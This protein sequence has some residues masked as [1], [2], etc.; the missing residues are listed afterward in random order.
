VPKAGFW[1][2]GGYKLS[3]RA[4]GRWYADD[5]AIGNEKIALLFSRSVRGDGRG[6]WII[7]VG[8]DR[9]PA[10]VEDTPLVVVSLA[11]DPQGGFA[12]ETNDGVRSDL[13]CATLRIGRNNVLYCDVDRGDR[14]VMSARFLRPAYY[15][16][17]RW[18]EEDG[19]G[20]ALRCKGV[21]H[22][23]APPS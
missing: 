9:Q 23:L 20:P 6:G 17:A 21:Q 11:G 14:G 3:F 4:D 13:D 22:R 10:T 1:A 7:D 15:D 5:E 18:I 16:L 12:V 8:I 19:G 2:I